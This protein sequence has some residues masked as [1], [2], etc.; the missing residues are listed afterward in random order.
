M[1]G[2]LGMGNLY[3]KYLL[4]SCPNCGSD[5]RLSLPSEDSGIYVRLI[6]KCSQCEDF[7]HT[8]ID[9]NLEK[10]EGDG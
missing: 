2:S 1:D 4:V 7:Y 10:S 8:W 5:I 9:P 3:I 6:G